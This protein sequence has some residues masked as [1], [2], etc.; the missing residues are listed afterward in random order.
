MD[1]KVV[2]LFSREISEPI[3][4]LLSI[5]RTGYF[6]L[7]PIKQGHFPLINPLHNWSLSFLPMLE[8][9][10]ICQLESLSPVLTCLPTILQP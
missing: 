10:K 3:F 1:Y 2:L 7:L 9:F 8:A 5:K 4:Y 6:L